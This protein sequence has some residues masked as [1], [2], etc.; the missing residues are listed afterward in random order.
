MI[1]YTLNI[2]GKGTTQEIIDALDEVKDFIE[3]KVEAG[4]EGDLDNAE[5]C[6]PALALAD[7]Q[8]FA[9]KITLK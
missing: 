6:F 2:V 3:D 1:K 5:L 8:K 9:V 4:E 7:D